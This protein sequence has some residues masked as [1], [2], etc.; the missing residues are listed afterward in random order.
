VKPCLIAGYDA[1]G[2]G[3]GGLT[4]VHPQHEAGDGHVGL[5]G[6]VRLVEVVGRQHGEAPSRPACV[7]IAARASPAAESC[8]G[9]DLASATTCTMRSVSAVPGGP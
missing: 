7:A 5:G 4:E 2:P 3:V 8:R 9:Y 6:G 1:L